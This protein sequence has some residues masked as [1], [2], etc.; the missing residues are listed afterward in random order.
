MA[1]TLLNEQGYRSDVIEAQ[2][3][4][5]EKCHPGGIQPGRIDGCPAGHGAIFG[6]VM[7]AFYT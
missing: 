3:S 6:Q 1:C 2:L 4:H 5:G 7:E